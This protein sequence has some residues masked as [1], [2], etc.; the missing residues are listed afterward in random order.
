MSVEQELGKFSPQK[1][2][3]LTIGVFDGVHLGHKHLI[4]QLKELARKQGYL[5]GVIT[6]SQH[7]QEVLSPRTKLPSLT[8]IDQ[9]IALLK[10]EGVDIVL[11][12][13]FTPQIASLSPEQFL[14]LL[15]EY[16]K[17]KGLVIGPD[18]ALGKDRQGDIDALRRL[19]QEMGFSVT[20]VPPLTMDGQVVSSTAI[21]KALAEGDMKQSRKLLGRPFSLQGRVV[22]GD[23]RGMDLG[24]PTANLDVEP[25]QAL[26][27]GG[28]YACRAHIDGRT[29]SAMTNIGHRPTF[30]GG[31]RM[32]E[33]YLLD[34]NGD[35]YGRELA[36]DIIGRLRDEKK[37]D[38]PEQLK[39]QI[40][41]DIIQGKD[42]LKTRGGS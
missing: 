27:A 13:P 33:V 39:E 1:E 20:V 8:G 4:A 28:V 37:F 42:M 10:N 38:T 24:F 16:L 30:G 14:S 21:R 34:Y 3:L 11:P 41:E 9:R 5:S 23:K 25:G 19:G 26:P 35:L 17:M 40:A 32:V 2:M 29:Y 31:Q 6:F 36:I 18:F 7:P 22:A 12:L 15:K